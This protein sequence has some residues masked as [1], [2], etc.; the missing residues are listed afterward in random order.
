MEIEHNSE[1]YITFIQL[2]HVW[3]SWLRHCV[4]NWK[5]TGSISDHVIGI[6]HQHNPSGH[7]MVLGLTQPL[8]EMS[9][10]SIFWRVKAAGV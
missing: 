4:T 7:T 6:F 10:K 9:T 8:T 1:M 2:G 5:V 3:R